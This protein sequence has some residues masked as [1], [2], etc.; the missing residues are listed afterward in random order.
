MLEVKLGGLAD[1]T[2][3][4]HRQLSFHLAGSLPLD[5]DFKQALLAMRSERERL[6]KL[7]EYYEQLLPKLRRVLKNRTKSA[8]N[9]HV[10]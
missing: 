7:I 6:D 9:G 1:E 2:N 8:G 3:P 5:L 4:Q 10:M